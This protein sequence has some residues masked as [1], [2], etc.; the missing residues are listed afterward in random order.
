M[1]KGLTE[2][3]VNLKLHDLNWCR[4]I[5]T[6]GASRGAAVGVVT[7]L[8]DVETT[9][10]VG[11]VTGDVPGDGSGGVLVSLLEGDGTGDLR[12]TAED[13]NW[14]SCQHLYFIV[15]VLFPRDSRRRV[16]GSC[17]EP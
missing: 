9:L 7:E 1:P 17:P 13:S 12:V 6:V 16:E 11:I 15:D 2:D 4:K 14:R 10:S 5:L 3:R 8:V